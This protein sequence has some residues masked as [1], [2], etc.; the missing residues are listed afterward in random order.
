MV[1]I[2]PFRALR[3]KDADLAA[4]TSPPHDV[5][6][7]EDESSFLDR[8]A[9]N[10][11]HVILPHGDYAKA[12]ATLQ[13]WMADGTMVRDDAPALYLYEVRHG[14]PE[15]RHVMR[16]L[17][18]KLLLDPSY[19][20]VKRHEMTLKKK[21]SERLELLRAT[22]VNT[23]SIWLSYRDERG[24]VE[25]ILTSNAFDELARFTDEDGTEH[26]LWRIDRPEAVQEVIAQFEDRHL[27]I[28]DGHHRYQT[29]LNR[30]AE[31]G[32][33]EHASMLVCLVRD[34]DPGVRIEPTHRL[35]ADTGFATGADAVAAADAWEAQPVTLPA[36]D[37]EAGALLQQQIRDSRTC[38]VVAPDGAWI[39]RLKEGMEVQEGRG[40]LD[41]LAVTRVHDRLLSA[42]GITDVEGRVTFTQ[43]HAGAVRAGRAGGAAVLLHPEPAHAVLDVCEE[44]HLMPQKA[45]FFVPK[46]RSGLLMAPL[47]E[48][49]P[50]PLSQQVEPGKMDFRPP[51]LG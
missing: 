16:G 20:D 23:E 26:R 43:S 30:Y 42:W 2:A 38:A 40:T 14:P 4:V 3:Y 33:P 19:T 37:A 34:T 28:A 18:C 9:K 44:G 21:K 32:K 50:V 12:A 10:V 29:S 15:D 17:F 24:W 25:E 49:P 11:C 5:I 1:A 45:T 35:V 47:D 51:P 31:T 27:V 48:A 8:D 7:P 46:L 36:D 41:A 6:Q 39:L 13:A 22:N